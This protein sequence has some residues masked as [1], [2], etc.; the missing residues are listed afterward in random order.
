MFRENKRAWIVAIILIIVVAL[1]GI[2]ALLRSCQRQAK[3]VEGTSILPVSPLVTEAR[4]PTLQPWPTL[5]VEPGGGIIEWALD[6]YITK[7][8]TS[9]L[10]APEWF[11]YI[12]RQLSLDGVT[13]FSD[14]IETGIRP[15]TKPLT[16]GVFAR[17]LWDW[18]KSILIQFPARPLVEWIRFRW[19]AP[20]ED[21]IL[22]T[23]LG[24]N[25]EVIREDEN[26]YTPRRIVYGM[27]YW[28]YFP[29]I[30]KDW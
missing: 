18:D 2:M 27:G 28:L 24:D 9:T 23:H 17:F 3:V 22:D 13:V 16:S 20:G 4:T 12:D 15:A 8:Y 10:D 11:L 19:S 5:T 14:T 30:R 7:T 25:N 1:V 21:D 29:V 26:G 6:G